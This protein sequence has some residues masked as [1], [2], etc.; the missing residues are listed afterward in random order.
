MRLETLVA[1]A[2]EQ[3]ASDL[4]LEAGLA[5]TLRV[6]G[7][8]KRVGDALPAALLTSFA[9][10]LLGDEWGGFVERGSADLSRVLSGQRCRINVLRTSRGVG[11]AIRLLTSSQAT[12]KSL[13]LHPE[14][15]RLVRP[16]HGLVLVC[17]PTGAGKSST[18]AALLQEVNLHEARHLITVE[19]PVEYTLT[20][21]RSLI[22]QR[23]VGRDTPSFEQALL[24]SLREDPDVLMVG[25]LR[26]PE[27]MRLTLSAAETGHL[28]LATLHSSRASEG[29]QR[30]V[31]AFAPEAQQAVCAQLADV[32]VGV[33]A[34][35]LKF[36]EPAKLVVPECE[37]LMASSA[38]RA[39]VRQGQFFKLASAMETA[40]A[41]GSLTFARYAEWL[42]KKTD[43]VQPGAALEAASEPLPPPLPRVA[44]PVKKAAAVS[45]PDDGALDVSDADDDLEHLIEQLE[46]P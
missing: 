16:T 15:V 24:D 41:D 20:P 38:V 37:L 2:R 3:G 21:K 4:H 5:A 26:E 10:E 11:F 33:V 8:L 1:T 35:R 19:S 18:L 9:R 23:E 44:R 36:H 43:F 12:L 42:A 34:Q 30:L 29:L 22:R 40:A 39:L 31:S 25:E 27:V 17:G 45:E 13:N 6:R 14:L 28:V 32:L 46:K 7:T